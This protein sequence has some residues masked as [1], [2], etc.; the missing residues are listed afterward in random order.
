MGK[1]EIIFGTN[2]S[3]YL[4]VDKN[5]K[6]ISRIHEGWDYNKLTAQAKYSVNF[7]QSRK[8]FV[9]TLVSYS[10]MLQKHANSKQKILK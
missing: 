4:H 7:T 3:S 8:R 6:Y 1:K 5:N 2:M 10:L 9:Y